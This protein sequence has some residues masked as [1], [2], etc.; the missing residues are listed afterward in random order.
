MQV[1]KS[2][3]QALRD[4]HPVR[5]A[6]IDSVG[7]TSIEPVHEEC[8]ME[9][10]GCWSGPQKHQDCAGQI[11]KL[12]TAACHSSR[13]AIMRAKLASCRQHIGQPM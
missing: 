11:P 6:A 13:G 12:V 9:G 1:G 10:F 5:K 4:E 2:M 7:S 8:W 3:G